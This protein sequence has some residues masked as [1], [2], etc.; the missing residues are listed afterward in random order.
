MYYL[1][2]VSI[3]VVKKETFPQYEIKMVLNPEGSQ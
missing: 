2:Y 1:C 3:E